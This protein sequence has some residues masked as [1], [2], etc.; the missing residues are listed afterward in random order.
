MPILSNLTQAWLLQSPSIPFAYSRS[1]TSHGFPPCSALLSNAISPPLGL[2]LSQASQLPLPLSLPPTESF[3]RLSP[4]TLTRL[5]SAFVEFASGAGGPTPII[6][7]TVNAQRKKEGLPALKFVLSDIALNVAAWREH[8]KHSENISY[9]PYSVDAASPPEELMSHGAPTTDDVSKADHEKVFPL[10]CLS[11]HHFP[12]PEARRI[13]QSTLSIS[14]GFAIIELVSRH[15]SALI[16]MTLYAITLPL[17]IFMWF[18][19]GVT[20]L[21]FTYVIPIVPFVIA[22]NGHVSALRIRTF[23][24]V[25]AHLQPEQRGFRYFGIDKYQSIPGIDKIDKFRYLND[26]LSISRLPP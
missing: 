20:M 21:L 11:F 16:L 26:T 13:L 5:F 6:E 14:D 19:M 15:W 7:A 4:N 22:F 10:Y 2:I 24:E 25:M 8:A 18:P 12:D 3:S 17:V 9:V 23:E 1:T